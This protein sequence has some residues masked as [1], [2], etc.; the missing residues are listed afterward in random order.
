MGNRK[1]LLSYLDTLS[2]I[3]LSVVFFLFPLL[4]PPLTSDA[5]GMP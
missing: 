3:V 1:E 2:L 4:F 5:F